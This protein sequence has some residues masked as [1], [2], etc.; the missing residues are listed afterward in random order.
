MTDKQMKS[1]LNEGYAVFESCKFSMTCD[2]IGAVNK[3][4]EKLNN[5]GFEIKNMFIPNTFENISDMTVK[6]II[7]FTFQ[8]KLSK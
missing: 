3:F 2:T 8:L 4:I 6:N 7:E 5:R 1:K